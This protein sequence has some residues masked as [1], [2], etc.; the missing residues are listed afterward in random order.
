M[1][2]G[3]GRI[4]ALKACVRSKKSCSS[5]GKKPT[6]GEIAC[7]GCFIIWS[8]GRFQTAAPNG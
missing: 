8:I 5:I 1:R 2:E 7:A 4:V 6:H 3:R